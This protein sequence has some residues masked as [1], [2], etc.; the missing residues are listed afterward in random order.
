MIERIAGAIA[1]VVAE[2]TADDYDIAGEIAHAAAL[3]TIEAMRDPTEKM[4][5]CR[6]R[7][8]WD[9][10]GS[11][12]LDDECVAELWDDMIDAAL[13]DKKTISPS[14]PQA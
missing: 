1:R 12:Y 2:R 8:A 4:K 13:D 5:A 10:D 9:F 11:Q 14:K 7:L 3:A 6:V